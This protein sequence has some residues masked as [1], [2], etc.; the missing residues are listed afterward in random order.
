MWFYSFTERIQPAN[1]E[2]ARMNQRRRYRTVLVVGAV[3]LLIVGACGLWLHSARRQEALNRQL[4][5]ALV[6]GDA[7]QALVLVNAGADPNTPVEPLPA[8]SLGQLWNTLVR[9]S[10]IPVNHS[11]TALLIACGAS[12]SKHV[13]YRSGLLRVAY[14]GNTS[15]PV[16][17]V[18]AM[19]R[20]GANAEAKDTNGMT[21]V[22]WA[23]R[24][25]N[26]KSLDALLKHGVNVN[27]I[28]DFGEWPLSYAMSSSDSSTDAAKNIILR[29]LAHGADPNM[30]D[31]YGNTPLQFAQQKDCPDFV[32]LLKQ[33]GA[34]K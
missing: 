3:F 19:L 24:Q 13:R 15:D 20:H 33:A 6:R 2:Q 22:M 26:T 23:T 21:P 5:A 16:Q 31:E 18:E 29:L 14:G 10:P 12:W 28:S 9:R 34:K 17:L 4:I 11:P 1:R 27:A 7:K 30:S 32:A 8:A 25:Q